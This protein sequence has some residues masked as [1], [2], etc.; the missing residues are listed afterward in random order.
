M[1]ALIRLAKIFIYPIKST[2]PVELDSASVEPEGLAHDRRYVVTNE[3]GR[4]L[5]AR[6][7]PR[8][9]LIQC[10]ILG[11]AIRLNAPDCSP[12]TL[13]PGSFKNEY[14]PITIWRDTVEAQR[15]GAEVN[16]WLSHVLGFKAKLYY[17]GKQSHRP[18]KEGGVVSFADG[19]PL[20]VLSEATVDD[21]NTRLE[22]PVS[23]RHFRPNIVVTGAEAYAEDDWPDFSI[24][25]VRFAALRRCARCILTTID[26]VTAVPDAQKQPLV[27]L[28]QYRRGDDG[29]TYFGR[30]VAARSGGIIRFGQALEFA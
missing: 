14:D 24:G 9:L 19:A 27:T 17:M 28:M 30:N 3:E 23:M 10:E 29:Q 6:Q 1:S 20:L 5:T 26:P 13:S 18:T 25:E 22:T 11:D 2:A 16:D 15:C 4:F 12:L 8:L 7:V 21:L